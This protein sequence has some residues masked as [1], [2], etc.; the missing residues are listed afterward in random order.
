MHTL[1]RRLK[2][3]HR[4]LTRL[5]QVLERQ[6]DD[7]HA[8]E[9]HDLDL[10]CELVEYLESYEDQMH[11]PTEDLVFARLKALT[12]EKRVAVETLEDQ[13]RQLSDMSKKFRRSLEAIMHEGV[14]LRQEVESQGRAMIKVLRQHMDL[15]EGEVFPLAEERLS[16]QDWAAVADQAPNLT[17]PV[18]G[19]PD[20]ARFRSLFRHLSQELG[21]SGG[22]A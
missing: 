4:N 19:D 9:E 21:L 10:M 3:D 14:V 2:T 11:H 6:L 15:E 18:F 1:L 5:L 13:H 7:F 16:P 17:D 12:D 22:V 20:P 8:G